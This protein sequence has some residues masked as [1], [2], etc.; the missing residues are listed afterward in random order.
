MRLAA[1]HL[2]VAHLRVWRDALAMMIAKLPHA[3]PARRA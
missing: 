2:L 1:A 3:R